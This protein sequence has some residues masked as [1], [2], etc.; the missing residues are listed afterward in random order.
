VATLAVYRDQKLLRQ[1]E[2]GDAPMRIGRAPENEI[3]LEDANK[4]VSRNH[5]EIRHEDGRY[6]ILDLNSQNGVWI[7]ERRVK[8]EPLP[9]DEPVTVG[10]YRLVLLAAAKAPASSTSIPGTVVAPAPPE[11]TARVEA[12]PQASHSQQGAKVVPPVPPKPAPPAPAPPAPKP[13]SAASASGMSKTSGGSKPGGPNRTL[14]IAGVAVAVIAAIGVFA[15]LSRR[16][17]T[18][19]PEAPPVT[20]APPVAQVT[21][22]V[23][24]PPTDEERFREHFDKAQGFIQAG[25]KPNATAENT[26]ALAILPADERG[27]KQRQEI[28]AIGAPPPAA[29]ETVAAGTP[30]TSSAAA[31]AA[32]KKR[33]ASPL[34]VAPRPNESA[35]ERATRE[36]NARYL[37]D[38]GK[39]AFDERRFA[40]AIDLLQRALEL[41]ERPDFG[42]TPGEAA[43][44][45]KL[46]RTAKANADSAAARATAQKLFDQ[47]KALAATDVVG[48]ARRLRDA[49]Q[50]DSKLPGIA[51]L[52]ASLQEQAV[53]QGE[54]ALTSAKN[55]DRFKRI[56][57]AIREYDR[58]V[59]L[60]ELVPG[61]HKDLALAKQRSAELKGR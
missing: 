31:L 21:S 36:K 6:V 38:D 13:A 25:D 4:G 37:L 28:E 47:A 26:A 55:F 54:A 46:A 29:P 53:T 45:L 19:Q 17:T 18:P 5:A 22:T 39:K 15:M 57:D 60:L 2:L 10:P 43:S 35:T 58:A 59:Q 40:E 12:T 24:A 16:G 23:P 1:V 11:S 41:S 48:A 44:V 56:P 7:R 3:V 61:G 52:M 27:L 49:Q 33:E 9:V 14:V 51:E 8:V 20:E 42:A 32:A 30:S 50:A 34:S